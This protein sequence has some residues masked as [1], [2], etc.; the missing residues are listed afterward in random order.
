MVSALRA[1]ATEY[2][3][4]VDAG[5]GDIGPLATILSTGDVTID[6]S[7]DAKVHLVVCDG[8]VRVKR[9]F[10]GT[11]IAGGEVIIGDEADTDKAVKLTSLSVE[12]FTQLLRAKGEKDG[13]EYFV[14]DVFRDVK[15]YAGTTTA[16]TDYGTVEVD[17]SELI[18]YERWSKQ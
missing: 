14:L 2:T 3:V 7:T 15:N 16:A 5:E 6:N 18:I 12:D 11:I 1:S 8:D 4:M 10:V 17:L 9:D 13:T